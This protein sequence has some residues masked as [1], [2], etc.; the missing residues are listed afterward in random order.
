MRRRWLDNHFYG[1]T[2]ALQWELK[3]AWKPVF[4]LGGAISQYEGRHFGELIWAQNAPA[5]PKDFVYYDNN[6]TKSDANVFLKWESRPTIRLN[7]FI[8]LQMRRVA[9]QF[10]GFNNDLENVSQNA[11]LLFFNPK[12][13][14]TYSLSNK[15]I[16]AGFA[17]IA[18]REP[19]RDDYLS[20]RPIA[21]RA[22]KGC[23]TWKQVCVE[24]ANTGAFPPTCISWDTAI[25]WYWMAA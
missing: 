13:G 3:S 17:G 12:I 6:A 22:L 5:A 9:Y 16:L 8:D 10:L 7:T 25:N 4:L 2:F 11:D 20:P 23:L 1:G 19:N 14:A 21:G 18:H 24:Q 15:W